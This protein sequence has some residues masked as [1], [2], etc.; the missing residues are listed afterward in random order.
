[1][2]SLPLKYTENDEIQ[3][4]KRYFKHFD[5]DKAK[6]YRK[7]SALKLKEC[8]ADEQNFV[9]FNSNMKFKLDECELKRNN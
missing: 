5:S 3:A 8:L 1:M 6:D 9:T 7:N 4:R 2:N